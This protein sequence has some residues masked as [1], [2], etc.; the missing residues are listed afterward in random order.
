MKKAILALQVNKAKVQDL[1]HGALYFEINPIFVDE[2]VTF[3]KKFTFE[4]VEVRNDYLNRPRMI[5]AIKS[6]I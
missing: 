6:S 3:F 2:L 1:Q 4:S 5:K